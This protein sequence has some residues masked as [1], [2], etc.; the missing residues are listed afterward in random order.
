ME[1]MVLRRRRY[2]GTSKYR[3]IKYQLL[4]LAAGIAAARF[5]FPDAKNAIDIEAF[6]QLSV[7][8]I[9]IKSVELVDIALYTT[10]SLHLPLESPLLA[11]DP[12]MHIS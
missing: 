9:L 12:Q 10:C 1:S 8:K 4:S 3:A 7:L 11:S 5:R 2:H 6:H